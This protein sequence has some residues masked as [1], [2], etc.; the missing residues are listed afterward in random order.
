MEGLLRFGHLCEQ[1]KGV[2]SPGEEQYLRQVVLGCHGDCS[3][4]RQKYQKGLA[5]SKGKLATFQ[6]SL[7]SLDDLFL[8]S[9]L[10]T[11]SSACL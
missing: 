5:I 1:N 4:N 11:S 7:V 6:S 9:I 3:P 8:F 10:K 2:Q